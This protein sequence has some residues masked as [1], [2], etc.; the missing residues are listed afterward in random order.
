M[1]ET[2]Q[3]ALEQILSLATGENSGNDSHPNSSYL[4]LPGNKKRIAGNIAK[5]AKQ[6]IEVQ[7]YKHH[8]AKY[9]KTIY[10]EPFLGSGSVLFEI[11]KQK[12]F[13]QYL[14]SDKDAELINILIVTRDNKEELVRQLNSL[15]I[16]LKKTQPYTLFG[17]IRDVYR[18]GIEDNTKRAAAALFL[19]R[20]TYN[21]L[22]PRI[23]NPGP[24]INWHFPTK[25]TIY[26]TSNLLQ[27]VELKVSNYK[28]VISAATKNSIIY[29]DPPYLTTNNVNY[30]SVFYIKDHIDLLGRILQA[31]ARRAGVIAT[32]EGTPW[33]ERAYGSFCSLERFSWYTTAG[34]RKGRPGLQAAGLLAT[35]IPFNNKGRGGGRN[36]ISMQL[37]KRKTL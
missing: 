2:T 6:L 25:S 12:L 37:F 27:N 13:K 4:K 32:L 1:S 7:F 28:E 15:I 29:I 3:E 10:I 20:T 26:K 24:V 34:R 23:S 30:P 8:T 18:A 17:E 11:K 31:A 33:F 14:G 21:G 22:W 19:N 36:W 16:R 9:N 35:S 5:I